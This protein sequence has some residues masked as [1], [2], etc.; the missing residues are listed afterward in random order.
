MVTRGR[1]VLRPVDRP[2]ALLRADRRRP[3]PLRRL[4]A[5]LHAARRPARPVLRARGARRRDRAH[6][7]RALERLLH[8][9]HREEAAQPLSAGHARA[10][11]RHG[12]LQPRLP[13]LPELGHQQVA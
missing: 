10:L 5:R 4:P 1:D 3:R 2:D 6:E 12:R 7:L 8:R 13:V 9:P 11:V